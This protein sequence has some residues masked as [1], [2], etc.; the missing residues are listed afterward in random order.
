M[1]QNTYKHFKIQ[2]IVQLSLAILFF[3]AY[4]L[5][6]FLSPDLRKNVY[7]NKNLWLLCALLWLFMVYSFITLWFDLKKLRASIAGEQAL[8][9]KAYLDRLT[10]IPNRYSFDV[11]IDTYKNSKNIEEVGCL[12]IKIKNLDRINEEKGHNFGDEMIQKFSSL[13]EDVTASRGFVGRNGGNEFIIVMEYC[14]ENQ[15]QALLHDIQNDIDSKKLPIEIVYSYVLNRNEK[16]Q[17]FSDVISLVYRKL[18]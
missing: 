10:G 16:L 3:I 12:L 14:T 13:L 7:T 18:L 4:F 9:R 11:L 6:L 15:V 17:H 2:K 8:I 1:E 5:L